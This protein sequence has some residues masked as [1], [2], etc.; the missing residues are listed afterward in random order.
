MWVCGSSSS[1]SLLEAQKQQQ[2]M[3]FQMLFN[4]KNNL[5]DTTDSE[6]YFNSMYRQYGN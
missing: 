2:L 3:G 6:I 5:Y 4:N 1:D